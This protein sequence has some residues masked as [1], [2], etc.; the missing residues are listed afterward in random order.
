MT[1]TR[2]NSKIRTYQCG[3]ELSFDGFFYHLNNYTSLCFSAL[4]EL[5]IWQFTTLLQ[6][7]PATPS[8]QPLYSRPTPLFYPP[9]PLSNQRNQALSSKLSSC[10]PDVRCQR[11]WV[12]V[13]TGRRPKESPTD[14][15]PFQ[16]PL[17]TLS[18]STTCTTRSSNCSISHMLR[19]IKEG[20]FAFRAE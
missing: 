18:V 14:T 4:S 1:L 12:E 5:R 20:S 8:N 10:Q 19:P 2:F 9:P 3:N 13:E 16:P 11:A 15:F 17:P 6:R 7:N